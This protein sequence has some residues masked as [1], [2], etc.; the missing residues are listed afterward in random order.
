MGK[1]ATIKALEPV[2]ITLSDR[3]NPDLGNFLKI[4]MSEQLFINALSYFGKDLPTPVCEFRFNRPAKHRAD[5]AWMEAWLLVEC[6][7]GTHKQGG[8]RHGG[9]ADRVKLNF[10]AI[11]GY[12]VLRFSTDMLQSNP[13]TCIQVVS[14]ALAYGNR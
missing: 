13:E 5:F 4:S 10:A 12:R 2:Y 8:G 7:G 11:L 14:K 9:D 1:H 3:T 6:D